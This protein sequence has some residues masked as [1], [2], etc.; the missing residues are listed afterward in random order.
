MENETFVWG[1]LLLLLGFQAG[2]DRKLWF[3]AYQFLS[4]VGL[5]RHERRVVLPGCSHSNIPRALLATPIFSR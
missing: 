1:E 5:Y 3:L 2:H 4:C